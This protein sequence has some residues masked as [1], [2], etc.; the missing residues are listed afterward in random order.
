MRKFTIVVLTEKKNYHKEKK[1]CVTIEQAASTVEEAVSDQVVRERC[2]K[3]LVQTVIKRQKYLLY[4]RLAD[5]F[6]V[7]NAT[8]TINQRD[9]KSLKF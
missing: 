4:H 1:I 2:T 6:T 7:E 3:Q 5:Q 9:F 8:R